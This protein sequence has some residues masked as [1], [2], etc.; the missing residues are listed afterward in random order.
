M[1]QIAVGQFQNVQM[2]ILISLH[3]ICYTFA[4]S[5]MHSMSKYVIEIHCIH[6][7]R[8]STLM[9]T[10]TEASIILT[11]HADPPLRVLSR[12]SLHRGVL[13]RKNGRNDLASD[14]AVQEAVDHRV[15]RKTGSERE[16]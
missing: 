13:R 14:G 5:K 3:K 1:K 8:S 15:R 16:K 2:E 12:Q 4:F 10:M 7:L 6:E 9:P 11:G